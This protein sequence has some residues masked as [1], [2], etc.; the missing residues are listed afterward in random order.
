[1]IFSGH[2]VEHFQKQES[3]EVLRKLMYVSRKQVILNLPWGFEKNEGHLCG[4][5]PEEFDAWG[6]QTYVWGEDCQ[7]REDLYG[8]IMTSYV[9]EGL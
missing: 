8:R 1:M 4:W 9:R 6:F 7:G 2:M 3:Q 5:T